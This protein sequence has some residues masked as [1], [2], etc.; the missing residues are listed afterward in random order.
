MN[1]VLRK[2]KRINVGYEKIRYLDDLGD[3][4]GLGL[5]LVWEK[6]K[7][8]KQNHLG[9]FQIR[10]RILDHFATRSVI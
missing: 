9:Q 4:F 7:I 1:Q 2:G 3:M 6:I 8:H 5:Y 10:S